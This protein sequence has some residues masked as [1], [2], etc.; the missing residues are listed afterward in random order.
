M[1]VGRHAALFA[2]DFLTEPVHVVFTEAA[3]QERASI[4]AGRGVALEEDLVATARVVLTA[5]EVVHAH[6]VQRC[7]GGVRRNVAADTNTRALGAVNHDGCVPADPLA[8][9]LFDVLVAGEIGL[10]C[11]GDSV[12]VV[13]G[14]QWRKRH[15]LS[16]CSFEQSQHEEAGAVRGCF[17]QE[18]IKG[19]HPLPGL[20]GVGVVEVGRHAVADHREVGVV[21][22]L[23]SHEFLLCGNR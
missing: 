8:V 5:E 19:L 20:F 18:A 13:G 15:A 7:G 16:G 6:F 17:F 21:E 12:D 22:W 10:H 3:F 9:T 11:R 14:G 1:R 2:G 4:H 23:V